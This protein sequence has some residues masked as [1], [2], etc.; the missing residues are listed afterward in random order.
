[1]FTYDY[2]GGD[3]NNREMDIEIS[4]WSDPANKNAQYQIQPFHIPANV[5][6][7]SAPPG[8]LTHSFR[9]EPG[10]VTFRTFRGA[11]AERP[12]EVTNEHVFTSGVPSPGS[13]SVK[14]A[15]YVL[16]SPDGLQRNS[17]EVVVDRFEYLP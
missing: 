1:M 2:A 5:A 8:V 12:S 17:A 16:G 7:F 15:I 6:R 9:W 11:R 13:E 4:R 14:M 10:R 3:Q